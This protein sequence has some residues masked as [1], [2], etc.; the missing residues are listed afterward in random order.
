M[1]N[2]WRYTVDYAAAFRLI[3]KALQVGISG[4]VAF[5]SSISD[6]CFEVPSNGRTVPRRPAAAPS[7]RG[8][9]RQGGSVRTDRRVA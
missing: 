8:A 5:G 7:S 1:R 3:S 6:V 2:P 9:I 4:L